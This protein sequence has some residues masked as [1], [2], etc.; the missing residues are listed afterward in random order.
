[1]AQQTRIDWHRTW[2]SAELYYR[3]Y[4]LNAPRL[5]LNDAYVQMCNRRMRRARVKQQ[6]AKSEEDR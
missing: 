2:V 4:I 1:M 6:T 3:F 5:G